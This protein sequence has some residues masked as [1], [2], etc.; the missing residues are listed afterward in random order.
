[1]ACDSD[2]L[3]SAKADVDSEVTPAMVD[4]G[5]DKLYEFDITEPLE[6]EM[7]KAV[8]AVYLAMKAGASPKKRGRPPKALRDNHAEQK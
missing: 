1:M 4:A 7:R 2:W 5:L 3:V 6:T 8:A